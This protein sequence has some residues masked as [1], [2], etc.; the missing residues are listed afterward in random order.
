MV[1]P[2]NIV[3]YA[4][5]KDPLILE[6]IV[7]CEFPGCILREGFVGIDHSL[8]LFGKAEHWLQAMKNVATNRKMPG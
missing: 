2:R 1:V 7:P 4:V 6:S 3:N 5:S 8:A